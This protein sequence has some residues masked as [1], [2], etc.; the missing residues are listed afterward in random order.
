[1]CL[2][3]WEPKCSGK[4]RSKICFRTARAP[5][6]G[7]VRTNRL[8]QICLYFL[9]VC[10]LMARKAFMWPALDIFPPFS[11][12]RFVSVSNP[13]VDELERGALVDGI[14]KLFCSAPTDGYY[15]KIFPITYTEAAVFFCQT[16]LLKISSTLFSHNI[17]SPDR[18]SEWRWTWPQYNVLV[19][20]M[21]PGIH[22][23]VLWAIKGY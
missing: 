5:F 3:Q 17:K 8:L 14:Q 16:S 18:W 20:I 7:H 10:N 23:D 21:V 15:L 12:H 22:V 1:M 9:T 19:P 13:S 2:R 4:T 6:T 11:P